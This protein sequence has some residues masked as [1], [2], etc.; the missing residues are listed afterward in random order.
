MNH[1]L[2]RF[3]PV[4]IAAALA[5]TACNRQETPAPKTDAAPAPAP[6]AAA[7]PLARRRSR[8]ATSARSPAPLPTWARTTKT[9]RDS[10]SK[11]SMLPAAS[12][13]GDKT[14]KLDLVTGDDKADPK[15]GTLVAQKMI[16]D[17]VVAVV[18]HLNSGTSIPASKL[19]SDASLSHISPSATAS[20][21]TEQGFKTT[22]RVV[23]RDDKQ[24]A[25][26]ANFAAGP[27]KAKT[28]AV[29][30][31]RT[32]VRPGSGGRVREVRQ[33][34]RHEGR[35]ARIHER[36]GERLQRHSDQGPLD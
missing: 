28:V 2:F 1:Q 4:A 5:L 21:L 24:G 23:A 12:K 33:G 22:F 32:A 8:S 18:G 17:G 29:I 13:L 11:R 6:A 15:D 34:K 27:L 3:A 14:F 20:K 19:Y 25:A 7:A 9:A 10:P 35:R 16:D 36:Q 30:D 26:L 31:D